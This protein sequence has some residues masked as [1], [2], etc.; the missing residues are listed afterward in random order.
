MRLTK[1]VLSVSAL[2]CACVAALLLAGSGAAASVNPANLPFD[3]AT[4]SH[5][6]ACSQNT[7]SV[8]HAVSDLSANGI[9]GHYA[10]IVGVHAT[11]SALSADMRSTLVVLPV[12]TRAVTANHGCTTDGLIFGVGPRTLTPGEQVGVALP[13]KLRSRLCRGAARD[14]ERAIIVAHTVFPTNCWNLNQGTV[15]LVAYVRK[16][17]VRKPTKKKVKP[18]RAKPVL[19]VPDPS[20][21]VSNVTCGNGN[22]GTVTVT[23]ANGS[24]ATAKASFIV[25]GQSYGPL[26][27][28][29]TTTVQLALVASGDLTISVSSGGQ[30]LIDQSA[31]ADY[32][33]A[34]QPSATAALSCS[35]GGVVVTLSNAAAATQAASF[36]VNGSAY[37]P[38][39][40]GASQSVT[41]PVAP[42]STGAIMV[43]SGGHTLLNASSYSNA[44]ASAPSALATLSCSQ[45]YQFSFAGG[46]IAVQLANGSGASLPGT[47]EVSATGNTTAGY[48]PTTVGPLAIGASRTLLIPVDASG[49]PVTVTI[50]S[51]STQLFSKTFQGCA[52]QPSE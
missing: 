24:A 26:A 52:G 17:H 11:G 16:P 4:Q 39:V 34:S 9:L 1:A 43:T 20:A 48:G 49:K 41:V 22:P 8:P 12:A 45:A 6:G 32:C 21:T 42:G 51:G 23:L 37:G 47:F 31:P 44:C 5:P 27:A 35:A 38:L 19:S 50:S 29:A 33:P 25:N 28:G 3:P 14:C 2:V 46:T 10:E 7:L 40:P 18:P 13:A 30:M 15:R 36:D